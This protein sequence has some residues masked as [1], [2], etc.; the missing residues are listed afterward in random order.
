MGAICPKL[1]MIMEVGRGSVL[2]GTRGIDELAV[3]PDGR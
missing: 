2:M 1:A 3:S